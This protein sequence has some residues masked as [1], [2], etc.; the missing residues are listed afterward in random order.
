[1][2][3]GGSLNIAAGTM[4]SLSLSKAVAVYE[5]VGGS[6]VSEIKL[7]DIRTAAVDSTK[8][9]Y[10]AT[11]YAGDV[12]LLLLDDVTGNAYTYGF[13]ENGS[14]TDK[15][16][17]LSA[18]NPTTSVTN[19]NG[20]TTAV[21][22][23]TNLAAGTPAGIAATGGGVLAGYATLTAVSGV[24]RSSFQQ[25]DDGV[26]YVKVSGGLIEV[27]GDVQCYIDSTSTW[28]TLVKARSSSDNM[29]LYYDK[30]PSTG[31]K[32]RIIIAR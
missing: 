4:G 30:T 28:T 19:S 21:L 16:A 9:R 6:T 26:W 11:D 14:V 15:S 8:V 5:C 23:T 1:V 18:T 12:S 32:I 24:S 31:G 22:G 27:S 10:Y 20:T 17:S 25:D 13:I 3:P 7:S 2:N 29:T